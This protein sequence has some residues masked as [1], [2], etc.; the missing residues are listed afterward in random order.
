MHVMRVAR[1]P[2]DETSRG[3]LSRV[4]LMQRKQTRF[5]HRIVYFEFCR[6]LREMGSAC[7][8]LEPTL[9]AEVKVR[10]EA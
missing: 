3:L 9:F 4:M 1:A 7:G 6:L 8:R 2:R 10:H 5:G